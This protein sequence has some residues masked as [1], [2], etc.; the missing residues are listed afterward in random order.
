[1]VKKDIFHIKERRQGMQVF[2]LSFLLLF[3]E[4]ALIRF[5]PAQF[6]FI[7]YFTNVILIASFFGIGLGFLLA[8]I[9]RS[10]MP[11]FGYVLLLLLFLSVFFPFR[12]GFASGDVVFF[13]AQTT[14][15]MTLS[16]YILVPCLFFVIS[17][18][19][20]IPAQSLGRLFRESNNTLV[21][22]FF[23]VAGSIVGV[24]CFV[25]FSFFRVTPVYW[26]LIVI[27][28]YLYVFRERFRLVHA[29]IVITAITVLFLLPHT[30]GKVYWS[31][32]QK[33]T[34][35]EG[36][37]RYELFANTI[38][39]Q[40]FYDVT[41]APFY[42]L[43]Y[44]RFFP[45]TPP[46]DVLIIGA[47]TGQD[48]AAA[49]AA[50]VARVDAVEIDPVIYEIGKTYHPNRPYDDSRV[51]VYIDDG[52]NVLKR[53]TKTYDLIIY[54]LP[55]SL[56]LSGGS[57]VRLESYLFTLEGF[58]EAK[59]RLKPEG[60]F[61]A[62]NEY[63]SD[64]LVS[65]IRDMLT[66][67]FGQAPK[68]ID[69]L[70]TFRV[71]MAQNTLA[72]RIGQVDASMPTD[73]WPFLYV[74]GRGVPWLY[75]SMIVIIGGICIFIVLYLLRRAK[76]TQIISKRFWAFFFTGAAFSLIETKSIVQLQLL[77][78]ATWQVSAIAFI[79]ILLSVIIAIIF[80][81]RCRT[82]SR[83]W[84]C[85]VLVLL[86]LFQYMVPLSHL[87]VYSIVVR[88]VVAIIFFYL[89]ITVANILFAHLF[90]ASK[91][92]DKDLG[93][94]ML[95]LVFGGFCEYGAM[96]IGYSGLSL[97]AMFFYVV[98]FLSDRLSDILPER[99]HG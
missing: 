22:Y 28:V 42:S 72:G 49:L 6:A 19:L 16:L 55:D 94:N 97:V 83:L 20:A 56:L 57:Q 85:T 87:M 67:T 79:G 1:M 68:E 4:L 74:K 37:R 81:L 91:E 8:G 93:T 33:L 12:A 60:A 29:V 32:Y 36:E 99:S 50:G 69:T 70:G 27:L 7:G 48:V 11:F 53:T 46:S 95:G 58:R 86:L 44:T 47:G 77:F 25:M 76:T 26:F 38:S 31:P 24:I 34:L 43:I 64:W 23:D 80:T 98:A 41:A 15:T 5:L 40:S 78:G 39:H 51:T 96:I 73:D 14:H 52:R 62:Y 21:L 71:F 9:R 66:Y 35:Y 92:A 10:L 90:G 63:R 59:S 84:L 89:P 18:L 54:A 82:I 61:I 45:K 75:G 3:L 30:S 17:F 88:L 13:Q 65:R 2:S